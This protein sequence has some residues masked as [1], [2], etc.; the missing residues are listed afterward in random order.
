MFSSKTKEQIIESIASIGM[1]LIQIFGF[2]FFIMAI[3]YLISGT[4]LEKTLSLL[5]ILNYLGWIFLVIF[6]FI[7][8]PLSFFKK[9]R[10]FSGILMLFLSYIFGIHLWIFSAIVTYFLWG[11]VA[12]L[13]GIFLLG[14]GVL[15]FA[16]LASLFDGEWIFFGSLVFMTILTYGNRILGIYLIGKSEEEINI[17]ET[18][19]IETIPVESALDNNIADAETESFLEDNKEEKNTSNTALEEIK[20]Q[21]FNDN[22]QKCIDLCD[23]VLAMEPFHLPSLYYKIDCLISLEDYGEALIWV[24]KALQIKPDL[25]EVFSHKGR[26]LAK[27]E[28]YDEAIGWF[29]RALKFTPEDYMIFQLKAFCF[30]KLGKIDDAIINFEKAL[31]KCPQESIY[32]GPTNYGSSMFEIVSDQYFLILYENGGAANVLERINYL[33]NQK[34]FD[35]CKLLSEKLYEKEKNTNA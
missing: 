20:K 25:E 14:I 3:I 18:A 7:L 33:Y 13:I 5:G 30:K 12:L 8:V 22:Y 6:I 29:D 35:L 17:S 28:K 19:Q 31:A 23:E 10:L 1:A 16:I 32:Y 9:T 4:L 21:H 11:G 24:D 2:I 15:P 34:E 27:L 26:C